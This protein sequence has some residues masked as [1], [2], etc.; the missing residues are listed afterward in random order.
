MSLSYNEI[1]G[2]TVDYDLNESNMHDYFL[3]FGKQC[4]HFLRPETSSSTVNVKF[5]SFTSVSL[6]LYVF[7]FTRDFYFYFL[8]KK[9][10]FFFH[11]F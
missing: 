3:S 6:L 7:F 11:K 9:K 8:L 2:I 4:F 1:G 10:Y 5:S